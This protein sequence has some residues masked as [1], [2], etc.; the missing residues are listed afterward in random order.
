[1]EK[2]LPSVIEYRKK[3]LTSASQVFHLASASPPLAPAP[4]FVWKVIARWLRLDGL[5]LEHD[6]MHSGSIRQLR[7]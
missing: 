2:F 6:P 3:A 1:M 5:V 4:I 7:Q